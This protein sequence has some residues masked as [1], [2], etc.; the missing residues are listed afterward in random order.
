MKELRK[1]EER[2]K[3]KRKSKKKK[4]MFACIDGI[5]LKQERKSELINRV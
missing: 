3:E 1:Q 5:F 2:K 4:E